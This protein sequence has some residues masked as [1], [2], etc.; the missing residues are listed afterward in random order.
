MFGEIHKMIDFLT[1]APFLIGGAF[2]TT[3][4]LVKVAQSEALYRWAA[5]RTQEWRAQQA[6]KIRSAMAADTST[7]LRGRPEQE[8]DEREQ[9][10]FHRM[11]DSYYSRIERLYGDNA[12]EGSAKETRKV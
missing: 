8:L 9:K 4:T 7:F 3:F 1:L 2:V 6:R 5:E 12:Q 10:I 11:L